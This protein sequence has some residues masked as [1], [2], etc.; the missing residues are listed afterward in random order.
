MVTRVAFPGAV[1]VGSTHDAADD[2]K[3]PGGW[4]G[5]NEVSANQSS[6]TSEVD[7]TGLSVTVTVNT[8]RR[9]K[10]TGFLPAVL[11]DVVANRVRL[12]IK[13]STTTLQTAE[14]VT[15]TFVATSAGSLEA[16]VVLT[17]SA[18]SHTYKLSLQ[19]DQGSGNVTMVAS[20]TQLASILVEDVGPSA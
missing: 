9:I 14:I 7:L 10:I 8:S 1:A 20:S 11:S 19:R 15:Q 17:P 13:E 18:G 5:Y 3:M 12:R 4:I 6:I 2:N 16:V